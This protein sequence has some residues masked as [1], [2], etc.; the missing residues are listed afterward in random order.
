MATEKNLSSYKSGQKT[1]LNSEEAKKSKDWNK[2]AGN[3]AGYAGAGLGMVQPIMGMVEDYNTVKKMDV[4]E[5][6]PEEY[7]NPYEK[8]GAYDKVE[9]PDELE[10]G[11]GVRSFM[12]NAPGAAM[13]GY[14]LGNKIV[15][16]IGGL[17]G[18]SL[19]LI[20]AGAVAGAVGV[21]AKGKRYDFQARQ[22]QRYKDYKQANQRYYDRLGTQTRSRAQAQ[23]YAKRGQN[24]VPYYN[25][26][27]YGYV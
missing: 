6:L 14:N 26:S 21:D 11:A 3:V 27:I 20:G 12:K 4:D 10:S 17:V 8:P 24:V 13:A 23:S 16:G 5:L 2:I 1:V 18:G 19:A 15:P 9:L 22:D 7:Y 25:A